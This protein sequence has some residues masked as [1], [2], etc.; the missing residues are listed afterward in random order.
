MQRMAREIGLDVEVVAVESPH[1]MRW[2]IRQ[3]VASGAERVGVAGGDGTVSLAVQEL[4]HGD[5]ALGIIPQGTANN[6]ATALRLPQDLPS[7]LRVL[8]EGNI[9]AVGLGKVA[10]RYFTESAGVGL[11]AD[12]L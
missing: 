3:L 1:E 7:A 11:F 9:L 8:N 2:R 4:A 10:G 12:A 5:T 6:F